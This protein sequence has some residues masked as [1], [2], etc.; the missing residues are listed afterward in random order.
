MEDETI[1]GEVIEKGKNYVIREI[2]NLDSSR[3]PEELKKIVFNE[4]VK[5]KKELK[6]RPPSPT[7]VT[8][9]AYRFSSFNE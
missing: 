8:T 7:F 5:L 1:E 9:G 3:T 6:A 2:C 4:L